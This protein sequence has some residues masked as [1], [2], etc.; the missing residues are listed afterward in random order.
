MK[1]LIIIG[2]G[3]AGLTSA[4]YSKRAGLDTLLIEKESFLGGLPLKVHSIENYPGFPD[5]ISGAELSELMSAQIKKLE[6]EIVQE[7]VK[8]V[9]SGKNKVVITDKNE[10]ECKAIIVASGT[11]HKKL[12]IPGEEE[13]FGKGISY[14]ATCDGPL[15]RDKTVVVV[16]CGNSGIQEGLF[17]LNYVKNIIFIE[18]LPHMTAEYVLQE[19]LLRYA[20]NDRSKVEFYFEHKL[21]KI[22]GNKTVHSIIINNIKTGEEKEIMAD[23]IFIYAGLTPNTDFIKEVVDVDKNGFIITNEKLETSVDGIFAAGDVRQKELRQIAT[24]IGDGA[25]ASYM[26][27][28][29]II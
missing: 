3:P 10:Y 11:M 16:G 6:V 12:N 28:K 27:Q 20:R 23:G 18:V 4:I 13:F 19:R 21:K 5:G 2:G 29:Y 1:E 25:L 15:F 24:A 22:L 17:L 8:E 14:C 26:A 7:C 9:R